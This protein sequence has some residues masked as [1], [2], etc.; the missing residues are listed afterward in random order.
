ML[1]HF[2][3][4][5]RLKSD[6]QNLHLC[7]QRNRTDPGPSG[8]DYGYFVC[9]HAMCY[10][11]TKVVAREGGA[12]RTASRCLTS[13]GWQPSFLERK[14]VRAGGTF[15]STDGQAGAGSPQQ[16]LKWK[17]AQKAMEQVT[18]LWHK[19]NK[20]ETETF[21]HCISWSLW[22]L[23]ARDK[24]GRKGLCGQDLVFPN[25]LIF[26]FASPAQVL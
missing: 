8:S 4:L 23:L 5:N 14:H 13:S 2:L 6:R 22:K 9:C 24:D 26:N 1:K 3:L 20:W 21:W 11:L 10:R 19:E 7:H 17:I 16:I 15:G 12:G 18:Q 25:P